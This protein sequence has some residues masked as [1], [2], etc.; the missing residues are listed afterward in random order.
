MVYAR[1]VPKNI[2]PELISR[3]NAWRRATHRNVWNYAL[4]QKTLNYDTN[5]LYLLKLPS[6][7]EVKRICRICMMVGSTPFLTIGESHEI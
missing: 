2:I 4:F 5:T 6:F 7:I 3:N 1:N